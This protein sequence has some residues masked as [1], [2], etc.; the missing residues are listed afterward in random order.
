[1]AKQM[2]TFL[3]RARV[4]GNNLHPTASS[5]LSF[6][7]G[8]HPH[9]PAGPDSTEF[10]AVR[11]YL[12]TAKDHQ[13]MWFAGGPE[14]DKEITEKFGALFDNEEVQTG[15]EYAGNARNNLAHIILVD[16]MSRNVFRGTKRSFDYDGIALRKSLEMI[17]SHQYLELRPIERLF[18]LLPL[19]HSEDIDNHKALEVIVEDLELEVDSL[20]D[21]ADDIKAYTK[22]FVQ[23]KN[24]HTEVLER[25]GR[26]PH[27]N[28]VLGRESTEEELAFLADGASSWGQ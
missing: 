1:M 23:F 21:F 19:E 28:A 7:F 27:R 2:Q 4:A 11:A 25:F 20:G 22:S 26:Y 6:W 8:D 24:Q 16:Q 18:M 14:T 10:D 15:W 5:I 17:A 3:Q 9:W 13:K 12:D